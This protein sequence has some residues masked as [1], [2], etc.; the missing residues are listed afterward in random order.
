[1]ANEVQ[2]TTSWNQ[3]PGKFSGVLSKIKWFFKKDQPKSWDAGSARLTKSFH[4]TRKDSILSV[5]IAIIVTCGAIYYWITVRN[6]YKNI[7]NR[8][9]EL[10]NLSTYNIN[11]N[12]DMLYQ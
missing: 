8:S 7:N 6:E 11:P 5:V 2:T 12:S 4:L 10:K 3:E 9:D 1:M